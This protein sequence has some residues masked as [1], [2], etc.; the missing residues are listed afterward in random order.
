[1]TFHRKLR[2]KRSLLSQ[3]DALPGVGEARRKV[4][5]DRFGSLEQLKAAALDELKAVPG[6]PRAVAEAVYSAL[7]EQASAP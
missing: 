3:L 1:V 7:H 6:L 2:S 5:L 4:L